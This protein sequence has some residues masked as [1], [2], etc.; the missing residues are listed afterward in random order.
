MDTITQKFENDGTFWAE[1]RNGFTDKITGIELWGGGN[2]GVHIDVL[3]SKGE[4]LRGGAYIPKE[5]MFDACAELLRQHGYTV[6]VPEEAR[7]TTYI[8]FLRQQGYAVTPPGEDTSKE[9]RIEASVELLLNEGFS[10]AR[11]GQG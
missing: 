7:L 8:E 3:S 9:A 6:I 10:V 11:W 2:V 5:A 1:F 4:A